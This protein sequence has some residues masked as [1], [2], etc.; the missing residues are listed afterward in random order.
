MKPMICLT[1]DPEML[2]AAKV[3]VYAILSG[4]EMLPCPSM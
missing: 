4:K 3:P 1:P 2:S